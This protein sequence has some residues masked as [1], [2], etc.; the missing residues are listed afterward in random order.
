MRCILIVLE[1]S[2]EMIYYVV[3]VDSKDHEKY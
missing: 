2:K 1:M 3:E